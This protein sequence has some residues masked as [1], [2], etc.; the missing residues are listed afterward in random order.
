MGDAADSGRAALAALERGLAAPA[1]D[2]AP[3]F[4]EATEKLCAMRNTLIAAGPQD[5][6]LL[7]T[8]NGLISSTMSGHFP[9]GAVPY[10]LLSA[11]RVS[12]TDLLVRVAG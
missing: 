11:A 7:P 4:A 1:R 6:A 3:F 2:A 12:L 10:P 5:R 8:V 9:Q